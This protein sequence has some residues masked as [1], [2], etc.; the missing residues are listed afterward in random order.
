M[1]L[2]QSITL[3]SYFYTKAQLQALKAKGK[4]KSH[5]ARRL[6]AGAGS[7]DELQGERLAFLSSANAEAGCRRNALPLRQ[8][9]NILQVN[10]TAPRNLCIGLNK[11]VS[12]RNTT[13]PLEE[14]SATILGN[15]LK[16][17][18]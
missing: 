15:P 3:G 1:P 2:Q 10:E 13:L 9:I 5:A 4:K 17:T 18:D 6:W 12:D 11:Q 7:I 14:D 16:G 8:E